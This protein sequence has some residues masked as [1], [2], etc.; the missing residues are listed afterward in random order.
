MYAL[1]LLEIAGALPGTLPLLPLQ[2][3]STPVLA[4][5]AVVGLIVFVILVRIAIKIAIRVGIVV[6]VLLAVLFGLSALGVDVPLFLF[7]L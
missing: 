7:G 3:L 1:A 6:A 2:G 5:L 4:G